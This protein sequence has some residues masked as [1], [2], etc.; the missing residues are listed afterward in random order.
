MFRFNY[1]FIGLAAAG[2]SALSTM[3]SSAV[4]TNLQQQNCSQEL[5][6][7]SGQWD[8]IGLPPPTKPGQPRVDGRAGH[9]HTAGEVNFMRQQIGLAE[10]SCK[11]GN[12]H[13]A[14]VRMDAVRA[15]MKFADV[16]HPPSHNYQRPRS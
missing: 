9:T 4:E 1:A 14:M 11:A 15:I 13:D 6:T 16:P 2:I 12:E 8:A 5:V 3:P 7:L 10:R